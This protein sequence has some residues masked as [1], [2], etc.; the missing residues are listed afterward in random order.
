FMRG[1]I[2]KPT[3]WAAVQANIRLA[4]RADAVIVKSAQMAGVIS[5]V[6]SHIVPNGVDLDHFRPLDQ[7]QTRAELGWQ[8]DATHILFPGDPGNPR[9]NYALAKKVVARAEARLGRPLKLM[10]LWDISPERV[11]LYMNASDAMLMMSL[12]EGSPNVVKEAM[13]C[14]VPVVSVPVGDVAELLDGVTGNHVRPYDADQLADALAEL[15]SL[16]TPSAGRDAMLARGL[17]LEGVARRIIGIY[18]SVL[19]R[20]ASVEQDRHVLS[21]SSSGI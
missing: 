21:N 6:H 18:E 10:T 19:G 14:N 17:D 5:H 2:R 12:R 4:S 3:G 11:P 1:G 7:A 8:P 13:A 15:L 9:K 16:G 20:D